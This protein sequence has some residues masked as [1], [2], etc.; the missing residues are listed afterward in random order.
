M[1]EGKRGRGDSGTRGGRRAEESKKE[2]E[3]EYEA[4]Q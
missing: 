1:G 4:G 2:R 3:K